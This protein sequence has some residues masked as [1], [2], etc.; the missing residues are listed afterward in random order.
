M[1]TLQVQAAASSGCEASSTSSSSESMWRSPSLLGHRADTASGKRLCTACRG[2]RPSGGSHRGAASSSSTSARR[3]ALRPRSSST[4]QRSRAT[5]CT[6]TRSCPRSR[7]HRASHRRSSS[8]A[9]RSRGSPRPSTTPF[10]ALHKTRNSSGA[11]ASALRWCRRSTRWSSSTHAK[12]RGSAGP[13][14]AIC[15]CSTRSPPVTCSSTRAGIS[16][17]SWTSWRTS[18]SPSR[19][20]STETSRPFDP[21]STTTTPL[22]RARLRRRLGARNARQRLTPTSQRPHSARSR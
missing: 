3:G 12:P 7:S 16:V 21:T 4:P 18:S 20:R 22:S 10:G 15:S 9:T 17:A 14:P 2:S 19:R 11:W 6:A 8:S 1:L 13:W 5:K